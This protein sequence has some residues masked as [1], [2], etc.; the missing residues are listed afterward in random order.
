MSMRIFVRLAVAG[1]LGVAVALLVACGSGGLIP[2]G[3]AGP[4]QDD[5]NKIASAANAGDCHT[6]SSAIR[7]AETDLSNLPSSTNS[8]LRQ[9][10]AEGISNLGHRA[11]T[12]C[13]AATTG[14]GTTATA[15][16][17]TTTTNTTTT[18]TTAPPPT[19]TTNTTPTTTTTTTPTDT[20]TSPGNGG[21]SVPTTGTQPSGGPGASGGAGAGGTP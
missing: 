18:T 16:T 12:Q 13:A 4:L 1:A 6:T 8:S 19:T 3:S 17:N 15:T 11:L 7:Q 14:S 10:L 20:T 21:T 5:F 2:A 9:R